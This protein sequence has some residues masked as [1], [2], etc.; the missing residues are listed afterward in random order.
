MKSRYRTRRLSVFCVLAALLLAAG[1]VKSYDPPKKAEPSALLKLQYTYTLVRPA[2]TL[3]VYMHIREGKAE[4]YE[5]AYRQ[6]F[7]LVFNNRDRPKV[8][9]HALAIRPSR[10]SA[11]VMRLAFWWTSMIMMPVTTT[12]NNRP[13]TIFLPVTQY[14]E[15]GCSSAIEFQPQKGKIYLINFNSPAVDSGCTANAFLQTPTGEGKFK[16]KAVGRPHKIKKVKDPYAP[17]AGDP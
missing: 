8:P 9:I 5:L 3:R 14:H 7:G 17:S 10:K 4:K 15:V 12:V 13:S 6:D 11:I 2:A 1:C 16:L